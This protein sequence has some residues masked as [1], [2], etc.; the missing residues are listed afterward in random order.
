[1]GKATGFMEYQRLK[2]ASEAPAARTKHY[3]EFVLHL[4]DADAKIQGARCMDCGIPFCN[5]GCPVNNIIPDWNDLVYRGNYKE[6][7]DTLHQT[8]NFPEFTGRICPAPCEA[9]CTLGINNDA[10]GI[11]SIEHFIIDKGWE[12]GWVVPQPAAV[13]TGKKVAVVGS[14]PAGMAAAQQLARAGHDVTVFE[15]SDRVGGLLRY[16][17]PD[18]KM[19]KSHIDLRVEQMKAEGVTFRTSVFVGKD[20]PETVNNWSKET[21]SPDELKKEFDAVIIAGGAEAPRDLP[22]PGRELKGVHFAMD[23]LPLQNKVNAGDKLKNQIM[24]T[25]KNV[26]VIGGGDTGSDCVGTSNRHG[27][28]A[29]T[30]FELMPQPPESENKPL[31]WPYWPI[32]L[33]TSSSHEEGCERDF[34]VTTKRLEGKGGKVEKLIAARVEFKDGKMVEVPDSE[35]EIKADLV[36][37]AMGF[38]SPVAQ[39]L[40]AFGVDKDARGNAK[41]TTD[42]EGCYKTSVDKVFAAGD[43]RRGQSL[44]VWAIREGRQC[45]RAV[46]EFLMGSS[47]LPR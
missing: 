44:V 46:D 9:A 18:F 27:A 28:A 10:V 43:M 35:F 15:K 23:F 31:V 47:L 1:M 25:G 37:L 7:L 4:S 34:A 29:V 13:K 42:G 17:I 14:G 19:E 32:K 39:V 22:V 36:L 2:E 12:N 30:Q 5:N 41:A 21:V 26:V 6:A 11:K 33:R 45:A 24:A 3:K 8:N 16:G 40:D 20:F 38:V